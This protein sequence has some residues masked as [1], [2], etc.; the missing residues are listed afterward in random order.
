MKVACSFET[1]GK[2]N[3]ATQRSIPQGP[4]PPFQSVFA[5]QG[6]NYFKKADKIIG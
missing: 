6:E 3:H 4:N 2:N 1:S 5:I